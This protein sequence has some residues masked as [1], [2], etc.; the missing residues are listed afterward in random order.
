MTGLVLAIGTQNG[1]HAKPT[2]LMTTRR[3]LHVI[4]SIMLLNTDTT[5]GALLGVLLGPSFESFF[6]IIVFELP[7]LILLACEILVPVFFA[8]VAETKVTIF[9]RTSHHGTI[10]LPNHGRATARSRTPAAIRVLL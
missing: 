10:G 1:L 9:T 2:K 8:V 5:A 7:F 6:R 4:A 3:A